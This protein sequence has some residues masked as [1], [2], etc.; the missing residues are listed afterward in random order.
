MKKKILGIVIFLIG[1]CAPYALAKASVQ[2]LSF[3]AGFSA[4]QQEADEV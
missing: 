2:P 4:D 3:G 1:I